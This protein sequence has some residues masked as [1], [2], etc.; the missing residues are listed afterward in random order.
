MSSPLPELAVFDLDMCCWSPEMYSLSV[1]PDAS[2][3][4][5][6]GKLNENGDEGVVGVKSGREVIA[7]FP[8]AL[9][10]LQAF[11]EGKYPG[12]RIAAASSADT[13]LAVRIGRTALGILE[14]APG[15]TVRQVFATGWP[16]GFEGNMQIGRSPP[17]S[18]HKNKSHFPLIKQHT[19]IEYNQMLFFDD[20]NWSD[21]VAEV[22]RGCPGVVGVRTP[23]G[24]QWDEWIRG[25]QLFAA[26]QGR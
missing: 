4:A 18:A 21:N 15:V 22:E 10:V 1:V 25:L 23:N 19:G 6:R 9:K 24:L 20:C 12:M 7:L 11:H 16:E 8:D 17:L 3:D 2:K 14:V 26:R 5:V 13:P